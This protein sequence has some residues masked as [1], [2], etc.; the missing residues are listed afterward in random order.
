MRALILSILICW[1]A[2]VLCLALP[3]SEVAA[4]ESF[5]NGHRYMSHEELSNFLLNLEV[6]YP[7]LAAR[8]S[9]GK[10]VEGRDLWV[11]ELRANVKEE[12]PVGKPM[13]KMVANMHGDE[14]VGRELLILLSQYLLTNYG[15]VAR[16]THLLNETDIFLMPSMNPDGFTAAR[17]GNCGSLRDYVGRNNAK[18][19][20]LNRDFPDQFGSPGKGPEDCQPETQALMKWIVSE[21]F[22]LSANLHGGAIVA[23]YPYD[24]TPGREVDSGVESKSPDN[25]VFKYISLEYANHNPQMKMGENCGDKFPQGIT[26]G[27]FWYNVDGG[28]QDF[29]Y[30]RSNA[31]EVTL[32]LSCCKFPAAS[33]LPL[34]WRN[35]SESL[36]RYL[37]LSHMG[38]KG[39]VV[40]AKGNPIPN[41]VV[42]VQ[43]INKN[44]TTSSRGEYWRLLTSGL[45]TVYASA[46]GYQSSQPTT[47]Q[48]SNSDEPVVYN[49]TLNPLQSAGSNSGKQNT[50][51]RPTMDSE[52]F[53]TDTIFTHHNY[54]EMVHW[55]NFLSHTYPKITR[56]YTIGKSVQGRDLF[57]LEI[58]DNP[59]R[60]EPGEPEFKYVANMHGNEVVGR[61]MLLLLAKHLC[62]QYGT[63][64]RVT[65]LV[66]STRIHLMPSMNPDG[67][68][69]SHEGDATS[70]HGRANGHR[71][72]LN[73]NFPDQYFKTKDNEVQEPETKAVM[74][75]IK[76]N[77]FVLSANL[78][79]GALVANYPYDS[80][81]DNRRVDNPSPDDAVFRRLAHTYANAHPTMALGQPCSTDPGL[82][83][84]KFPSGITNGAEWY[85]VP[86]GMQDFN[87]L[88]SNC[89]ELT[90]EMG[91]NKFPNHTEVQKYWHDHKES[92]LLYIEQVHT[93]VAGF[94]RSTTGT[95]LNNAVITVKGI[96]HPIKTASDGD[97]WRLLVPGKYTVTASAPGYESETQTIEVPDTGATTHAPSRPASLNFTLI[98]DDILEWSSSHD[99]DISENVLNMFK[100][101]P[102]NEL[103]SIVEKEEQKFPDT[104]EIVDRINIDQ[105]FHYKITDQVGAPEESKFHILLI[106]GLWGPESVG[107]EI[108]PRLTRHLTKAFHS[109]DSSVVHVLKNC[110]IHILL[111]FDP[112]HD[113]KLSCGL[114][115]NP[116]GGIGQLIASPGVTNEE[117]K[118]LVEVMHLIRSQ[119]LD[120]VVSI[121]GGGLQLRHST[122]S[123]DVLRD[124]LIMLEQ[125][126]EHS[127]DGSILTRECESNSSVSKDDMEKL[128]QRMVDNVYS[129][130]GK[131][132][133]S[134]QASCCR[135]APASSIPKLWKNNLPS[136]LRL[137][138]TSVQG[139]RGR[140]LYE[141]GDPVRGGSVLIKD[142]SRELQ[143]S[144]NMAYFKSIL[145]AGSYILQSSA[146]E[147]TINVD[148]NNLTEVDLKVEHGVNQGESLLPG[149]FPSP[150]SYTSP[151][152]IHKVLVNISGQFPRITRLYSSGK[153]QPSVPV[154]ELSQQQRNPLTNNPPSIAFIGGFHADE[155]ISTEIL[156]PFTQY[157]IS[158]HG[159]DQRVTKYFENLKIHI[160]PI[161]NPDPSME[162]DKINLETDFPVDD[163]HEPLL[164]VTKQLMSWLEVV[165]PVLV[166]AMRAGSLHVSIPLSSTHHLSA[167]KSPSSASNTYATADDKVFR[168]IGEQYAA[169]HKTMG[170]GLPHCP[171]S[172]TDT[173]EKGV[174]NTGQWRPRTG[175]FI[176]Y[177]YLKSSALAMEI[178]VDCHVLPSQVPVMETWLAHK[179]SLLYLLDV[180]NGVGAPG[181]SGYVTDDNNRPI[182][183]ARLL[184]DGMVHIVHS[185]SN[186][187]YWR[188]AN[189]GEHIVTV[190]ADGYVPLKKLVTLP[191]NQ[192]TKVMF[193]LTRDETVMGM[194]RLV[195]IMFAGLLCLLLVVCGSCC[196]ALCQRRSKRRRNDVYSF[197]ILSQR[198]ER[199]EKEGD[200]FSTPVL[201]DLRSRPYHDEDSTSEED[202]SIGDDDIVVV[203]TSPDF[204]R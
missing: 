126:Y 58:S 108:L 106:G 192:F 57:V 114:S 143:V 191:G 70:I 17:E 131:P 67:Y 22:V 111:I 119:P 190:E 148:S 120:L 188:L 59:G 92:L 162:S 124:A 147:V 101:H 172:P 16:I 161:V 79:G 145:H 49:F 103:R 157:L 8:H 105:M 7:H 201:N 195:F 5:V 149:E 127:L 35:N 15:K 165:K 110:V 98:R 198:A 158:H 140:L 89:F 69:I 11:L 159:K 51:L 27:A 95:P 139:I 184:L 113:D 134:V 18:G 86:G 196:Y 179:N 13:V 204:S 29:N 104:V 52:G 132:M 46:Y 39:L 65:E 171:K 66:D 31:F 21:P 64:K 129:K 25:E 68:E 121:D 123:D 125:N 163:D 36:L 174:T 128:R 41:A 90:I 42:V 78:H 82:L 187:A 185:G 122:Q 50:I 23:S 197:S 37:E 164:P 178:F 176:D 199:S 24:D 88:N 40:D 77:P 43:G 193:H 177:A 100:L 85:V 170:S 9:I 194:P 76:A 182:S 6:Q 44:V 3:T 107:L 155:G 97:Y 19:V 137:L 156:I 32:E 47:V 146:D 1:R 81:K 45:Y 93:G 203:R 96:D 38:L 33:D 26:N 181:F 61:E 14:T 62:E 168:L 55:L 173:F 200:M 87:Y 74:E 91:C 152:E 186:G 63:D 48:I 115:E 28:M 112:S 136:L 169:L 99:Y 116:G 183:D 153:L 180:V 73:R 80:T 34:Y 142:S 175:N 154:L 166:F 144:D 189:L 133:V 60:H 117:N 167:G 141:N 84:E 135:H 109:N 202:E 83:N 4:N 151:Q 130:T 2:S 30:L 102:F 12:R 118:L 72:D 75:W 54:T 20:D 71:V 10:S 150:S 160:I 56:L 94:V 138:S 53:M